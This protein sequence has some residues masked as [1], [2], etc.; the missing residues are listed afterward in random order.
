M[1][2]NPLYSLA[3]VTAVGCSSHASDGHNDAEHDASHTDVHDHGHTADVGD[4]A[5][6]VMFDLSGVDIKDAS[7][8]PALARSWCECLLVNCHDEFHETFGPDDAMAIAACTAEGTEAP[9]SGSPQTTGNSIECRQH[10]CDAAPDDSTCAD[11]LGAA[12]E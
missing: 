10:H 9:V 2:R 1:F 3:F 6:D 7:G 5:A 11:A 4:G 12:C 8:D